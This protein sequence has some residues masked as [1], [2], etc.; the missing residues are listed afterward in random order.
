LAKLPST[1]HVPDLIGPLLRN[2][3]VLIAKRE[4]K[5]CYKKR[6]IFFLPLFES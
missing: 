1:A 2:M 4:K 3:G 5:N 6:I